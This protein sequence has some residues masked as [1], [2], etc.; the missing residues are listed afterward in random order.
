M[1][2]DYAGYYEERQA[3]E[4]EA[5]MPPAPKNFAIFQIFSLICAVV[6]ALLGVGFIIF[7][8]L[9]IIG[10]TTF[11]ATSIGIMF[12]LYGSLA[13]YYGVKDCITSLNYFKF[14]SYISPAM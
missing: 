12:L 4:R 2:L 5:I 13:A 10:N 14:R 6:C 7:A 3:S 8:L 1:G 11:E 9:G